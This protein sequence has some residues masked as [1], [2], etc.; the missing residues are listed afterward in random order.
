PLSDL[1]KR[2]APRSET[3]RDVALHLEDA[4]VVSSLSA[5]ERDAREGDGEQAHKGQD[6]Q[7]EEG[8]E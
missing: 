1:R 6:D 3:S 4:W 7:N 8:W 5:G 2:G